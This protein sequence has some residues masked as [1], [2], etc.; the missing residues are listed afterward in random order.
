MSEEEGTTDR[1]A[2]LKVD[3]EK[4]PTK[5][6]LKKL[7]KRAGYEKEILEMGGTIDGQNASDMRNDND[8]KGIGSG[9]QLGGQFSVSQASQSHSKKQQVE[10]SMDIKVENFDIAAQGKL[11]FNKAELTIVY[12]RKYGLVGPNGMGKTTLLKHIGSRRLKGIP[13][14]IDILYCEQEIAADNT[15]AIDTV[16]KSDKKRLDLLAEQERLT[17]E[18]EEGD[19]G[20]VERIQQTATELRDIGSDAAEP[21]ARRILAGLGFSKEMQEKAVKDFSGGWRMRISLARALFLEPTLLML[22]EPTNHLDLNA[23]IWLDNYLQ[24]WKKTL[25][26]VSHDQGFLD[27][28]CTDIIHLQDQKLHY[29]KGNYASFK[30]MYNQKMKEYVKAYENQQ[31]QMQAL[32]K[33]GKSAKQAEEELKKNLQNKQNKQTKTKKGSASMGDESDVPPPELLQRIKEYNVKFSFPE[34]DKLAPPI[35]GLHDVTFGYG[36]NILVQKFG[37]WSRYGFAYCYSGKIEPLHGE[38]TKHRQVKIGWFDQHANEAL[39][40]EQ[41]PIEY[42]GSKFNID[43]QL[44]RKNL[45]MV[46]LP[47]HAHTVKIKDLSGG[48]KSRVAL[49]ELALGEPDMLILDEPTNNLDIESID[50]L[51]TAIENFGGG[52]VMVTHDERLVRATECTLWVVE[53]QGI[54]EIDGDFDTYKKRF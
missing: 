47:G 12:G 19:S 51:A 39:N 31:K 41:N 14:Y 42:L 52:V 29:Y 25:L 35:L 43:H 37:L 27:N 8:E 6:E 22:D 32:K 49:A 24:S 30:K 18:L 38:S 33:S 53:N 17:A 21:R 46:G 2:E 7:A 45:G 5:R 9:A 10:N 23:V 11:L 15:S 40:G 1:V 28:V 3:K 4:K 44:A 54:S 16:V 26:I 50:A 34:T 20:V 36:D 13:E 48:Q